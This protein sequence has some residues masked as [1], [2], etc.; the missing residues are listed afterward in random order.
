VSS[1]PSPKGLDKEVHM[2]SRRYGTLDARSPNAAIFAGVA[3]SA[4]SSLRVDERRD[5]IVYVNP[6]MN[7]NQNMHA[8]PY[9]DR[10]MD[11]QKLVILKLIF[12]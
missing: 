1:D 7:T 8:F 9:G 4:R 3:C 12:C 6:A 10:D 11:E 2:S 5:G